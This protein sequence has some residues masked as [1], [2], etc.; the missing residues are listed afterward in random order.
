MSIQSTAEKAELLRSLHIPGDPLIVTNV[1]DSITARIVAGADGVKALATASHSISEA[2]GVEDGEGL[3]VDE[4]LAAARLIIR[5]VDLPVSVDFEKAYA[6]DA[7]GTRDNVWRLIEA[8]AAG[9]NLEDSIG[10][11]KAELYDIDT[12][13]SKIA[14]AR[15]AG[16]RAGV[17]IVINARVDALAG[18]PSLWDDAM[19]RAN[20]YLDAGADVAFVLGLST[21]ETVER[22]LAAIHGKVSV[23]AN[24]SQVPLARLAELG[25]SR[26][27]FGPTVMGLT[28]SHLRDAATTL[29]AR[30]DY[31]SELGFAF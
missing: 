27:S 25:V 21:E 4:A 14:A 8:G 31:P 26:V 11:S 20:A 1:W 6:S 2:H 24:P 19:T 18:D 9:L 12:Q 16:D 7:A 30:G 17:P 13:V 3:D 23:I 22:A 28:L 29:T 15:A 10:R 5:S